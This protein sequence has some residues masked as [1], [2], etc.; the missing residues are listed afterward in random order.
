VSQAQE[1]PLP[2]IGSQIHTACKSAAQFQPSMPSAIYRGRRIYFCDASCLEDFKADPEN[3]CLT[4]H[5]LPEG[6]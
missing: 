4:S 2:E 1:I 5:S 3:S 6:S